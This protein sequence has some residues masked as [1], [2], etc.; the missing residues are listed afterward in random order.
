MDQK[1]NTSE[2]LLSLQLYFFL[3]DFPPTSMEYGREYGMVNGIHMQQRGTVWERKRKEEK[4][5]LK[6][7]QE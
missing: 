7:K 3:S 5:I 4:S 1:P 6:E 2:F